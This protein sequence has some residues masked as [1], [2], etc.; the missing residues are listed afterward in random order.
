MATVQVRFEP[1]SAAEMEPVA[2]ALMDALDAHP[3][4]V[5][6]LVVADGARGDVRVSFEFAASGDEARD[7][8]SA[9]RIIDAVIGRAPLAAALRTPPPPFTLAFARTH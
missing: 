8:P 6:P 9:Q 7:R 2:D 5:G 3:A 4:V 1:V